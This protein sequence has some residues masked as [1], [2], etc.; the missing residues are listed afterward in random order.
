MQIDSNK[1]AKMSIHERLLTIE[2]LWDS[3]SG[4][5]DDIESPDWHEGIIRDGKAA[6]ESGEA[7]FISLK[8][9]KTRLLS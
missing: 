2:A 3:L 5:Q 7:E 6:I 9:L 1:I 8:E 4:H